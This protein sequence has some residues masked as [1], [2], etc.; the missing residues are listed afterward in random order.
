[1]K[2]LYLRK[3]NPK[4]Y[5]S[6]YFVSAVTL[7]LFFESYIN[8]A[9]SILVH[10]AGH[11]FCMYMLKNY[12]YEIKFHLFGIDIKKRKSAGYLSDALISLSGP[13]F[14]IIFFLFG[15]KESLVLGIIHLL[16]IYSLDGGRALFMFLAKFIGINK[17]EAAVFTLSYIILV[18]LTF[19][20]FSVLF[21]SKN[22][23]TLLLLCVYLMLSLILKNAD[24]F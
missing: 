14:N 19:L 18:P 20:G 7:L 16:P 24:D 8:A 17:A 4:I 15:F 13:I 3:K 5:V 9:L 6:F 21:Y 22:N 2:L 23:F 11:L 10:E 1:M 12:P